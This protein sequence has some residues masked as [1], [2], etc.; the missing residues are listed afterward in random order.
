MQTQRFFFDVSPLVDQADHAAARFCRRQ[1][2]PLVEQDDVRQDL[3][4][5]LLTRLDRFDP[6]RG[7]LPFFA[8]VC[9]NHRSARLGV[10]AGRDRQ[11]RRAVALD[12]PLPGSDGLT[13]LDT[14][15]DSDGYSAWIGQPTDGIADLVGRLDFDRAV[16]A[17]PG[18]ALPICA[19]L[20]RDD[21]DPAAGAGLPRTTFYRRVH[22]LRCQLLAAG[23]DGGRGTE[24]REAE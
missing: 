7:S 5:D 12:A 21:P 2:G 6:A 19:A 17:L 14:L 11:A 23:I 18:D 22:E 10:A 4:L 1:A 8:A 13:V 24:R 3:L 20:M 16:S 15:S 9:F